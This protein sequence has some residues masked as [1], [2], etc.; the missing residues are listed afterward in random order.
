ME[1]K[2][3]RR[4]RPQ[5]LLGV[6]SQDVVVTDQLG[7]LQRPVGFWQTAFVVQIVHISFLLFNP[8]NVPK[9]ARPR[10]RNRIHHLHRVPTWL[11]LF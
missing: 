2:K 7:Q 10:Q 8:D 1:R 4:L 6:A 11:D 9:R 3:F 5:C